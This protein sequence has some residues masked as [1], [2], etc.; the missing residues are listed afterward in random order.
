M[1]SVPYAEP[2]D[3][4]AWTGATIAEDDARA[5]AVLK[6]ASVLVRTYVGAD[7][8][9]AW[10]EV[11][12][13]VETVVV[14]VASRVWFN[15]QGVIADT[16]DDYSRR[17]EDAPE[18]GVYLSKSEQDMLSPYRTSAPKGVWT[19]GTTRDDLYTDQY[20]DVIGQPNEPMPFLP[21]DGR[22]V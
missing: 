5:L 15:P 4:A 8:A 16:I 6:A 3:L 17:W 21:G 7:A 14:Q 13:D 19:L 1:S 22:V 20:I 11:P 9:E 18:A 2:A 12:D 10:I